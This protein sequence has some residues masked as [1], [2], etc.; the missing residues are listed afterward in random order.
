[1][2]NAKVIPWRSYGKIAGQGVYL[3][4]ELGFENGFSLVV[5]RAACYVTSVQRFTLPNVTIRDMNLLPA[6]VIQLDAQMA[7][8]E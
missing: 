4:A 5:L 7:C 1:M 8:Y 2:A 6:Q 3:N